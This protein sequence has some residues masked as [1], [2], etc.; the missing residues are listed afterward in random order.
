MVGGVIHWDE[1]D[2]GGQIIGRSVRSM[3]SSGNINMI[4]KYP[5]GVYKSGM[6]IRS[7]DLYVFWTSRSSMVTI[8]RGLCGYLGTR[9]LPEPYQKAGSQ[10]HMKERLINI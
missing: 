4:I 7:G 2:K 1:K 5:S 9:L 10:N 3:S 8:N 6:D